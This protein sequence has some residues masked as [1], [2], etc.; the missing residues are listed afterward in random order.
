MNHN[1]LRANN[2]ISKKFSDI[3]S[4]DWSFYS[5][6]EYFDILKYPENYEPVILTDQW[7]LKFGLLQFEH[8]TD[9]VFED[10]EYYSLNESAIEGWVLLVNG[11]YWGTDIK[12]VHQ[13]QNLYFALTGEELR[14]KI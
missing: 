9:Y 14:I 12:H 8:R 3:L 13:L 4:F 2:I 11:E 5:P 6:A 1:E 7:L 10:I